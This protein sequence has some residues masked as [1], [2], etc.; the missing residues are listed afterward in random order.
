MLSCNLNST[1]RFLV[2]PPQVNFNQNLGT[3]ENQQILRLSHP[4]RLL[5]LLIWLLNLRSCDLAR[6][7]IFWP[8]HHKQILQDFKPSQNQL[9]LELSHQKSFQIILI[10]YLILLT[11]HLGPTMQLLAVPPH[12]NCK[13]KFGSSQNE[14]LLRTSHQKH[15]HTNFIWVF[16]YMRPSPTTDLLVVP[17][18]ANYI[19]HL[20]TGWFWGRSTKKRILILYIWQTRDH[21]ADFEVL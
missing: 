15:I 13:T 2:V 1:M 14:L 6:Q 18:H 21:S 7:R 12:I 19:R 5:I 20:K 16:A 8:S 11:Y 9:I 10:L 17:P 3:S 4:E